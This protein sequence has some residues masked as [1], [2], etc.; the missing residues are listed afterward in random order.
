[1]DSMASQIT[2]LAIVYST[3]YSGTDQRK[4]QSSVS[5]AFVQGIPQSPVNSLPKW[6]VTQKMFPFDDVIMGSLVLRINHQNIFIFLLIHVSWQLRT[7]RS[8]TCFLAVVSGCFLN[9]WK[10]PE[11]I[12]PGKLCYQLTP[13]WGLLNAFRPEKMAD[14]LQM[15]S[16]NAFPWKKN[17]LGNIVSSWWSNWQ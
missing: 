12:V 13:R 2:S 6:P 9:C 7:S 1:M 10:L 11:A 8:F 4:H 5:L 3:I 16:S 17:S 14:I 15:K